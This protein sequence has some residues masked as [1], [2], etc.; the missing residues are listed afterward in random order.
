VAHIRGA[1]KSDAETVVQFCEGNRRSHG[2]TGWCQIRNCHPA[3]SIEIVQ[4]SAAAA[5]S[6]SV[7]TDLV[8][9]DLDQAQETR[10]AA[11][12][13]GRLDTAL[14]EAVAVIAEVAS[15][16]E[17]GGGA[18]VTAA[19]ERCRYRIR[20]GAAD[21]DVI[22]AAGV[23]FEAARSVA[24]AART[25]AEERRTQ[26]ATLAAM[27]REAVA[28][29][30]GDQASL[31]DT[32]TGSAERVERIACANDLQQIQAELAEEVLR[33]KR[34]AVERRTAWERTLGEFQTRLTRLER[35]LDYTK[36]EASIDPLTNVANRRTFERTCREWLLPNRIGFV[37]AMADVDDF[38]VI[39]DR[40][41]HAI[42]DRLLATIADTLARSLRADDVVARLGGDEF[43]FLCAGLT[44][45]QAE[46]RLM[47]IVKM[48]QNACR[49]VVPEG[50]APSISIGVTERAAGDTLESLRQRADEAL[51]EA[52]R[53]GKGRV[54]TKASPLIRDLMKNTMRAPR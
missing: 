35:Q 45:A 19:A 20:D 9:L 32:L 31:D 10:P 28:T 48:V 2:L 52:K 49:L 51:Y 22:A 16:G 29:V 8:V 23:C 3:H 46:R 37:M 53:H 40:Y 41:G 24:A 4:A 5:D 11:G 27:V 25:Q 54:A 13:D 33:L 21:E 44:L 6:L 47:G 34:I 15:A 30:A 18:A 43:A 26:I 39:N 12:A 17:G 36:R 42:G 1:G 38:K 50:P 7:S 14:G